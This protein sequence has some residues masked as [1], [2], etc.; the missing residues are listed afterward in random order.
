MF[1]DEFTNVLKWFG[2]LRLAHVWATLLRQVR[3]AF[4]ADELLA[5]LALQRL[6]N[7]SLT[8]QAGKM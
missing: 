5:D 8:L 3:R 2:L 4:C 6:H 7:H 1:Q